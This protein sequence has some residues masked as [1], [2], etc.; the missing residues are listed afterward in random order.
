[1]KNSKK[2]WPQLAKH[3]YSEFHKIQSFHFVDSTTEHLASMRDKKDDPVLSDAL[4]YH[5]DIILTG[6]KDFLE[7]N[8]ERPLIMSP[9]MLSDFLNSKEKEQSES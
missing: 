1:M 9:G 4:F 3:L 7:G 8:I 2:S 5:A 6:D